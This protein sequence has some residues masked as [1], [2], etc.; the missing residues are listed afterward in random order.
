M[1]LDLKEQSE[2][3]VKFCACAN[4]KSVKVTRRLWLYTPIPAVVYKCSN[5]Q[6]KMLQYKM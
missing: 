3:V 5:L 4:F 1:Y 2:A 6:V